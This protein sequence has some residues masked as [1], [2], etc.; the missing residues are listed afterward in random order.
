[1]REIGGLIAGARRYVLQPFV[2]R[3]SLPDPAFQDA[4]RTSP[5][6][7]LELQQL[8]RNHVRDVVTR[9]A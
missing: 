5:S 1:M 3:D 8:M 6:R 4:P 2:P 9:G 7:L